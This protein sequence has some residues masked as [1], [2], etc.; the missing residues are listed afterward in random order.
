MVLPEIKLRIVVE[1]TPPDVMFGLQLGSGSK[2]E[3]I[4]KQVVGSKTDIFFL[5]TI[6][7]KG[8]PEKDREPD[9]SGQ[10]VQGIAGARFIYLDIGTYAGQSDS[11][12]SRRLK[13]PLSGIAWKMIDQINS[14]HTLE[15][16]VP[17]IGKDGGP[18]CATVKPFGGWHVA[19]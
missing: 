2:Y 7:I 12:W 8:D 19:K 5:F 15:A 14:N 6:K 13:V 1:A 4:Q 18:N 11:I 17:G 10:Y 16:R 9:F 3:T